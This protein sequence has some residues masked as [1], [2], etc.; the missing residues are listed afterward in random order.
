MKR[1]P[2]RPGPFPYKSGFFRT[3]AQARVT[4]YPLGSPA[5]FVGSAGLPSRIR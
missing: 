5:S 4:S 2:I 1:I 3:L